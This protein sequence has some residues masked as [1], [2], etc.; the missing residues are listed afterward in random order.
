[1]NN[2]TKSCSIYLSANFLHLSW[3]EPSHNN[4]TR[5]HPVQGNLTQGQGGERAE[6]GFGGEVRIELDGH[7]LWSRL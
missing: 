5:A 1:M 2:T 3:N 4:K 6:D 7:C